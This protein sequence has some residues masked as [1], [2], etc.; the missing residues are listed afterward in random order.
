MF[1]KGFR[2]CCVFFGFWERAALA[3][4]F[5]FGGLEWRPRRFDV[6]GMFRGVR[7]EGFGVSRRLRGFVWDVGV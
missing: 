4:V 7:I 6:F 2:V 1:L 5:R 3:E